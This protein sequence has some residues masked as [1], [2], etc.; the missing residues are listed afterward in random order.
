MLTKL[1]E[2]GRLM[3]YLEQSTRYVPY[4]VRRGD[5]TFPYHMPHEVRA[6]GLEGEYVKAM[7][8]AFTRYAQA[9]RLVRRLIESD[10]SHAA[11]EPA[12]RRA[13]RSAALD[14][15]RG[16]LP[17]AT[18]SNVGIYGSGQAWEQLLA[19][20]ASSGIAEARTRGAEMLRELRKIIPA[21]V[22]RVDR[23]DRGGAAARYRDR[24]HDAAVKLATQLQAERHSTAAD[25][26]REPVTAVGA[27]RLTRFDPRGERAGAAG[28][29][30][31]GGIGLDDADLYLK[32]AGQERLHRIIREYC[33]E[34]TNRRHR[35]GRPF[36]LT[37]YTFAITADYSVFRDLQRHR[38]LTCEWQPLSVAHGHAPMAPVVDRAGAADAW[39]RTMSEGRRLHARIEDVAGPTAAQYAVPMAYH[40]RFY[41]R[42]NARE[43]MHVLELRTQPQGHSTYRAIGQ[44]MH[45]Q[46]RQRAGHHAVAD[47]MVHVDMTETSLGRL[48]AE[49]RTDERR[50]RRGDRT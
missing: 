49:R 12:A 17:A 14:A 18:E 8:G 48:A 9:F 2:R 26:D 42:M 5:G 43:L 30:F 6:A 31:E 24:R 22:R 23:Q 32:T 7:D 16:M 4:D 35:P 27:V 13:I 1:I 20:L 15:V 34:R 46:I 50:D 36:E 21:F 45:R 41:P 38:M 19:R 47:A 10:T 25:V 39:A 40:V 28:I 37:E 33:G 11:R 44:E 3:A 29:L